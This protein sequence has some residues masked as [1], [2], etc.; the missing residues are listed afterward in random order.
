MASRNLEAL[1]GTGKTT[2]CGVLAAAYEAG[3]YRVIGATPTARA[4]RELADAGVQ[5]DTI[6]A[7]LTRL[8]NQPTRAPRRLV[9]LAD[10]NGMAGTRAMAELVEWARR[11]GAKVI[12]VGDSQQLAGVPASGAFAAITRAYGAERL[13]EVRRQRDEAEIAALADLRAG[14]PERYLTHQIEQRRV[15]V[16]PDVATATAD[17]ADWWLRAADEY[18]VM[19]V[20]LITRSNDL[21]GDLNAAVRHLRTLRGDL[22]GPTVE[23]QR[24][25]FQRGDRVICRHNDHMIDVDNGTRGT[26]VY[27]DPRSSRLEVRADDG[28]R[29][30]LPRAYVEAGHVEHAY[31]LTAHS[32]QGATVETAC[33]VSR[34]DDHGARWTYTACSRA[35]TTTEHIVIN[36]VADGRQAAGRVRALARLLE[37]TSRD[38]DDQLAI[39]HLPGGGQNPAVAGTGRFES[40]GTFRRG[41]DAAGIDL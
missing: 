15:H 4:A 12:Q 18:G 23:V 19:R 29:L 27:A 41:H 40:P 2:V 38:D 17:A 8:R 9:I 13:T 31:A 14:L 7:I 30:R 34:P 3:G 6:D 11:G 16:V 22:D 1:A 36:D 39:E 33:V 20:A 24:V 5:A 37:A 10:E 21:R 25:S 26:I 32:L 28:R 35:R